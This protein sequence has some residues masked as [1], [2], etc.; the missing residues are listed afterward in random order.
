MASATPLQS[1]AVQSML[2]TTTELG[3]SG[4]F[5]FRP[6]RTPRVGS[7]LQST[8]QRSS[9]F[10]TSFASQ[11]RHQRSPR[12][13]RSHRR[14]GPRP[15]PSS[16]G[17]SGRETIHSNNTTSQ[18]SGIRSRRAGH[19]HRP[20]ALQ[21]LTGPVV[22]P[23]GLY[24]HRSLVTLRS[25]GDFHSLRSSS[26]MLYPG[27]T[28]RHGHRASSPAYS[29]MIQPYRYGQRPGYYRAGS[30]G[31]VAS[32]PVSMFPLRPGLPGY[33]PEL[34]NSYSSFVR[35]PSPAVSSLHQVAATGYTAYRTTTPMSNSLHNH[36]APWNSSVYSL[37]G[38]PKSPTE[39][40]AP[41]YYDYSESF[42]EEDSI[43]Q[44]VDPAATDV[45]FEQAQ[46]GLDNQ[47]V[48]DRRQAQ[49]PFG[50]MQGSSFQ[51]AELPTTHNRRSS[52]Q[53]KYSYAGVIPRRVSSLAPIMTPMRNTSVL[54]S[55]SISPAH[56]G[57]PLS[58]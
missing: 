55:V 56:S 39:S 15:V 4:P 1:S 20:H 16:S 46:P 34:N 22:G 30:V 8:R 26:P 48:P 7:R 10:D 24:T 9:S 44:A 41:H 27:Q 53:S 19:R 54:Q 38:L 57:Y 33:R 25:Q 29:E 21:G 43:H 49:S 5:A 6:S 32:S 36:R 42:W 45:P 35:M 23:H 58:L 40:T 51:P 52:E 3:N 2:K 14:H 18:Y 13:R 28:R 11:L 31:T 17:L 12:K 50:I 47:P 37:R